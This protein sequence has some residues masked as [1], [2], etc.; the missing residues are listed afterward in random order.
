MTHKKYLAARA[1]GAKKNSSAHEICILPLK[2]KVKQRKRLRE[3]ERVGEDT[4]RQS[5]PFLPL[6]ISLLISQRKLT[7][8]KNSKKN[9]STFFEHGRGRRGVASIRFA[10]CLFFVRCSTIFLC[11]AAHCEI[12]RNVFLQFGILFR[13]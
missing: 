7:K 8:K 12:M 6:P 2:Q 3:R 1:T 13:I 5:L 4:A 9:C 10:L 11:H